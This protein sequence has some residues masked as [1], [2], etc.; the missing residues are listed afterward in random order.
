MATN[1][2]PRLLPCDEPGNEASLP[3]CHDIV[4]IS[5]SRFEHT[6][7][8]AFPAPSWEE[9]PVLHTNIS[10]L[11]SPLYQPAYSNRIL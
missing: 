3:T 6:K 5:I 7:K 2:T 4:I 11:F 8:T 9:L 1:L 10:E